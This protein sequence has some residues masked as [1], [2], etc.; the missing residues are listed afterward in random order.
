[1]IQ[2][3]G[4]FRVILAYCRIKKKFTNTGEIFCIGF[5]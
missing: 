1:M 4:Q 3:V 2:Y 5:G